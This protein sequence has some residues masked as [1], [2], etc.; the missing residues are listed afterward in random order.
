MGKNCLNHNLNL[1]IKHIGKIIANRYSKL[2]YKGFFDI[3]FIVS[4]SGIPYPIETNVRR[5]G[6]THVFDMARYLFGKKWQD[7]TVVLSID[8]FYY[9][10][11]VLTPKT[12]FSKISK[13]NFPIQGKHKGVIII[14]I[15]KYKPTLSL[16]IFGSTK[17]ETVTIYKKLT[18]IYNSGSISKQ[19]RNYF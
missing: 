13:I 10:N 12:I 8:S 18:R 1:K 15:D 5:T 6:G 9:G 7:K 14:A 16:V 4:K 2:G 19:W 3:D 11:K 17:K